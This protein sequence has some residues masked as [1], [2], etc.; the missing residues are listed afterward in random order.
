MYAGFITEEQFLK[1]NKEFLHDELNEIFDLAILPEELQEN[2]D[3][4]LPEVSL[5]F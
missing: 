3:R 5:N 1:A 4:K 2:L